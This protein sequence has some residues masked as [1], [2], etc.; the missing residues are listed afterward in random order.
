HVLLGISAETFWGGANRSAEQR[1]HVEKLS[2]R[3]VSLA[4]DAVDA[5]LKRLGAKKIAIV[6]PYQDIGG[7]Q[8]RQFFG[9]IGYEVIGV[10]C[11][12]CASPVAIAEVPP[13]RTAGALR[14]LAK[15]RPD[16]LIQVGTNLSFAAD[17]PKLEAELGLPVIAINTA[18][19]RHALD[20]LIISGTV[21][22]FGPLLSE[23]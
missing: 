19:Y 8:V 18:L 12:P 1:A 16:A 7:D 9:E 13:S 17:A 6:A 10:T 20:A 11:L 2:G 15:S 23:R 14:E 5:A 22:G 3:S 21:E 4:S